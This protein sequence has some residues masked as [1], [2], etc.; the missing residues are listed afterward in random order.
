MQT[1]YCSDLSREPRPP[2][3]AIMWLNPF[4]WEPRFCT[5]PDCTISCQSLSNLPFLTIPYQSELTSAIARKA[6]SESHY[7]KLPQSV[8]VFPGTP[9]QL[10][11]SYGKRLLR[12]RCSG[13]GIWCALPS[14]GG[15]CGRVQCP[16]KLGRRSF[17][18]LALWIRFC[19]RITVASL[20]GVSHTNWTCL[21]NGRYNLN[22][23]MWSNSQWWTI[24]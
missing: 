7:Q 9:T 22:W 3:I 18:N 16:L 14:T 4:M 19:G 20:V 23:S 17:S 15:S 8:P 13:I 11:S 1:F 24:L 6:A 21:S 5:L 12:S 2:R 10:L